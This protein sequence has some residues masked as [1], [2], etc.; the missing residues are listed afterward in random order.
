MRREP[1]HQ[2]NRALPEL[3]PALV[4]AGLHDLRRLGDGEVEALAAGLNNARGRG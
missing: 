4:D 2:I 3:A 1:L